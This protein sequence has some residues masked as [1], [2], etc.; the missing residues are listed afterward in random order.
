[1]NC[2]VLRWRS[3]RGLPFWPILA[4]TAG[5][6]ASNYLLTTQSLSACVP[7]AKPGSCG[8][9]EVPGRGVV[10]HT[11]QSCGQKTVYQAP[12]HRS[13]HLS[14]R[15]RA[16]TCPCDRQC[17]QRSSAQAHLGDSGCLQ[18]LACVRFLINVPRKERMNA[19]QIPCRNL[20]SSVQGFMR[21]T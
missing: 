15:A 6:Q 14:F 17:R 3:S 13:P 11:D 16:L 18:G 1:M 21:P 20:Y 9:R 5:S 2:T 4:R 12:R 7:S 19:H 8:C 10:C